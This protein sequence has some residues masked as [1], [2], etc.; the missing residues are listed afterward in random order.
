VKAVAFLLLCSCAQVVAPASLPY[1]RID[2]SLPGAV[3]S[4]EAAEALAARREMDR[5]EAAKKLA[6]C[7]GRAVLA[8]KLYDA[9]NKRAEANAWWGTWGGMLALVALVVGGSAGAVI[10]WSLAK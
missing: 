7:N 6:E 2:R 9:A 8:G 3:C 4:R 1:V 5:G 10:G